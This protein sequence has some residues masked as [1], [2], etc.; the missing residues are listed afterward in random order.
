MRA[1]KFLSKTLPLML[2]IAMLCGCTPKGTF[3]PPGVKTLNEQWIKGAHLAVPDSDGI[4]RSRVVDVP[5][6]AI[7]VVEV[8]K[9]EPIK[10]EKD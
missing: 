3:I 5:P 4:L 7:I 9:N 6:G 2:L 10:A 8:P 1:L